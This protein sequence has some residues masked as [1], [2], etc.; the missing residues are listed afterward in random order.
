MLRAVLCLALAGCS[1]GFA[2]PPTGGGTD[3]DA[4]AETADTA[5][6]G[7][8]TPTVPVNQAPQ[9]SAGPDAVVPV[10]TIAQLDGSGSFDPDG[11]GLSYSWSFQSVP[12]GSTSTLLNATLTNASFWV[13]REGAYVVTL[14]VTDGA[15]QATDTV[16]IQGEAANSGP[17]ANAGPDQTVDV[18][19]TVQLNGSSSYDPQND[20]I[21]YSWQ[22]TTRPA[23]SAATITLPTSP[24]PQFVADVAGVYVVSVSVSDGGPPSPEDS[25]T[26]TA[27]EPPSSDCSSCAPPPGEAR[28]RLGLGDVSGGLGAMALPMLALLWQRHRRGLTRADGP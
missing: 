15:F 4:A 9:A 7:P 23:G 13:D 22:F 21:T 3:A 6:L 16:T 17:V 26:I 19:D 27:R 2:P 10:A 12:A 18:G 24:L 5:S 25:V 28:R 14:T 20:P 1:A 11:D 8:T